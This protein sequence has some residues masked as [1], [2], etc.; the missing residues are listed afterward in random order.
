M[1]C[2]FLCVAGGSWNI[3]GW[4]ALAF[5]TLALALRLSIWLGDLYTETHIGIAAAIQR[6]K[7]GKGHHTEDQQEHVEFR[8]FIDDAVKERVKQTIRFKRC[9]FCY[10]KILDT[11]KISDTDK[12]PEILMS[13]ILTR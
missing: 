6:R 10:E 4:I 8:E 1:T 7:C 13:R 3:I 11:V 5:F 2:S 9:R 12:F